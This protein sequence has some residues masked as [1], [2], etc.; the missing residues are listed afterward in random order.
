MLGYTREELLATPVSHIHPAELPQL[1]EF[2]ERVLSDGQGST[3]A[4][5]CRTK[6]GTFLPTEMS[7]H[8]VD[9]GERTYVLGLMLDRSEHRR[10]DQG[11]VGTYVRQRMP[12]SS[13]VTSIRSNS[14][15]SI[16]S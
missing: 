16:P 4:L 8:A 2:L 7:L 9:S 6:V 13:C 15:V 5:T 11:V 1:R 14:V 12:L 10:R 3:I